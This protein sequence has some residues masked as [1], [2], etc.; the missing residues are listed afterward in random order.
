MRRSRLLGLGRSLLCAQLLTFASAQDNAAS[1][2]AVSGRPS[3]TS[4]ANSQATSSATAAP[5]VHHIAVGNGA[6]VF[7]P[8]ELHNV[9]VG[10]TVTL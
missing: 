3:S 4:E 1:S 7:E 9:S 2:A 8:A 10:D 5:K 6:F